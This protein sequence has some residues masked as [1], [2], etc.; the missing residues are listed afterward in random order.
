M[1]FGL[2]IPQGWRLDLVGIDPAAQWGVMRDLATAADS[3]PWESLWVYDHFHTVP[4]PTEEATHEAW[5]LMSAFAA[6]TSRIR[7]GQMC[8]AMAYRNPAYLAKVA[9]TVDLISGGR[10]E[11]GIGAGW[12]EHEWRA[13]GYGF[14]SGGQR[15]G[16]LDEGVQIFK[17]AWESG[18]ATLD[19]K[20]Y[21]VDG[22]RVWPK[23]LQENGIPLWIAGGGEKVTL[24]IAAKYAD[25]TNFDG[26]LEGFT[27]KSELLR[28]HCET[29]GRDFGAIVR[30]A[31]YNVAIGST[32]AEVEDRLKQLQ[33]RL[34]RYVG[35]EKAEG[36]LG[37]FRGLPG[38]GTPEQIVE[39]LTALKNE[40]LGYGIFYF[41]EA[42]YDRTG[43]ELFEREVMPALS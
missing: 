43:I 39:N 21:Q 37:A 2:F 19:G 38:V 22:A 18:S 16:A 5:T 32:E 9:A 17:Q 15:L 30:S 12:Y 31:N 4:E 6:S 11:M 36:A 29:V 23:P 25:Y 14:P 27:H 10:V 28:G 40:G 33:D 26:T 42:A 1:R 24:K 20:Y 35:A 41:P 3:G 8:T 34:T 13:Y 7:L